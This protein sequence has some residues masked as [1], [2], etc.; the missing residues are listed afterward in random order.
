MDSKQ[1][2]SDERVFLPVIIIIIN[3]NIVYTQ[4]TFLQHACPVIFSL[5]VV[6]KIKYV[7]ILFLF[8]YVIWY[9]GL[10]I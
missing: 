2:A 4:V 10:R 6:I 5:T 7:Q 1:V 9:C 3:N 8:V